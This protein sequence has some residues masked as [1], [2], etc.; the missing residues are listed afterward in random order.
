MVRAYDVHSRYCTLDDDPQ[1]RASCSFLVR[2]FVY[3]L[4]DNRASGSR[5]LFTVFG[6]IIIL[7]RS[8]LS[9]NRRRLT[10]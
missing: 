2:P 8:R 10:G 1:K 3:D 7:I 6:G 4:P 5:S 9:D